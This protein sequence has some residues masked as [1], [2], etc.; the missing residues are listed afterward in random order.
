MFFSKIEYLVFAKLRICYNIFMNPCYTHNSSLR[1]TRNFLGM[2][3]LLAYLIENKALVLVLGVVMAVAAISLQYNL[4]Y[5][6]HF[7]VLRK[8]FKAKDEPVAK[9]SGELSFAWKMGA[10]FL[11]IP[12]LLFALDKWPGL[13]WTLVLLDGVLLLL[14]GIASICVASMLYAMLVK[15]RPVKEKRL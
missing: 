9:D 3:V 14:A 12:T 6:L 11:L 2:A 15:R 5:Q 10:S 8:L 7:L 4:V 13:A 1:F